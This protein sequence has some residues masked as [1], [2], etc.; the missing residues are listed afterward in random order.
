VSLV[1]VADV[2][3]DVREVSVLVVRVLLDI[4]EVDV[5]ELDV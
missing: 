2:V 5:S 1:A 4:S 3:L